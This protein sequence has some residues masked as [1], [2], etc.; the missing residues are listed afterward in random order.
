MRPERL[1]AVRY[2]LPNFALMAQAFFVL[3]GGQTDTRSP[4]RVRRTM[5]SVSVRLSAVCPLA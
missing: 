2:I 5:M 1:P 3:D 4:K